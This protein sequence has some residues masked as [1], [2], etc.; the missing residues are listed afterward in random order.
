MKLPPASLD[1]HVFGSRPT[2]AKTKT[3]ERRLPPQYAVARSGLSGVTLAWRA[4]AVAV[5]RERVEGTVRALHHRAEASEGPSN[6]GSST[7]ASPSSSRTRLICSPASAATKR[8]PLQADPSF[9]TKV[10]PDG[11]IV[12][13][14]S[15]AAP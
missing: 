10:A 14:K 5:A 7:V 12:Y 3:A 4:A 15:R 2:A 13:S 11:A 8:S 1:R 6:I 9:E